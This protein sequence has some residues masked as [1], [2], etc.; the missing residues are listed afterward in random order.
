MRGPSPWHRGIREETLNR[1]A[2]STLEQSA[3]T[4]PER[5]DE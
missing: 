2:C 5:T 4:D 1:A 3:Q